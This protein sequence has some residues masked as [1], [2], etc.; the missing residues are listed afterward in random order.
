MKMKKETWKKIWK[1]VVAVATAIAGVLGV[2]AMT[3]PP[4]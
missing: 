4:M 3:T 1:I 2:N